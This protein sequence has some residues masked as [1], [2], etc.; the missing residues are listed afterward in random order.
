MGNKFHVEISL[1]FVVPGSMENSQQLGAA[2]LLLQAVE[3]I[4]PKQRRAVAAHE[5]KIAII[6][7]HRQYKNPEE[8]P[9]TF[10]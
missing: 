6:A 10:I 8:L 5:Y 7:W 9:G 4:F 1:A 3:D 2:K